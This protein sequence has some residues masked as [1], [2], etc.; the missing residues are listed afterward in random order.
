M[1]F[2]VSLLR[3]VLLPLVL[4]AG[5]AAFG[6]DIASEEL[7]A[8]LSESAPET[9]VP[10]ADVPDDPGQTESSATAATDN[11]GAAE[12]L[13]A[14][15]AAERDPAPPEEAADAAQAMPGEPATPVSEQDSTRP[16][17][18]TAQPQAEEAETAASEQPATHRAEAAVVSAAEVS[19]PDTSVTRLTETDN[20]VTEDESDQRTA[21]ASSDAEA[22]EA[23]PESTSA[24]SADSDTASG[25]PAA[26]QTGEDEAESNRQTLRLLGA[27]VPRGTS[28]RLAWSPSETFSGISAPTPV[29]VVHGASAGPTLCLTAAVHGDE[30]TGIEI[31]RRVMF[32][33][34]PQKLNGTVVGVPIVNLQ[35]FRRNSRYLPDRRDLNRYFPGNSQGSLAERV[36]HSFFDE[37]IRHCNALVDL[38]TGSFHRTNLPQ[39]RADM[40]HPGVAE[41]AR[42]MGDILVLQSQGSLGTLRRAAVEHGIPAV[43]LEAGEPMRLNEEEVAHGVRSIQ[44]LLSGMGMHGT[45]SRWRQREPVY[46]K[47]FWVRAN[48]GGILFSRV[49]LGDRVKADQLLGTVTDPITNA[50]AELR[51][52]LAGRVIGM[53]LNQVVMPGFAAYHIGIQTTEEHAAEPVSGLEEKPATPA[54]EQSEPTDPPQNAPRSDAEQ[55]EAGFDDR[56]E[57]S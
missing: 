15:T 39:V 35:G 50:R 24:D 55:Q 44:S 27:E 11:S 57:D 53:A 46:Y 17:H 8:P 2:I 7:A 16:E 12:V 21:A 20:A 38:H 37:V 13:E 47:S 33:I 18:Q 45:M 23:A 30:L 54:V 14:P 49:K 28:T 41:L 56:M 42:H 3:V 9:S 5:P 10:A 22:G 1:R 4:L 40:N 43:T 36:A 48:N 52:P 31:V 29:L 26:D 32:G 6:A 34:N 51:S 25:K 19:R